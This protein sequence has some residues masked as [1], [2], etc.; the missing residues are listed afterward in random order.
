MFVNHD[1]T[2]VLAS[3]R[4]GTLRLSEDSHGLRV[5][6]DLPEDDGWQGP[7]LPDAPGDVDSMSFGFSVPRV[8]M[9]G[10]RMVRRAN[11]ARCVCMKCPS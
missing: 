6:A 5:E 10:R 2:R 1:T 9:R 11:F 4:A 3:K 8:A 7:C